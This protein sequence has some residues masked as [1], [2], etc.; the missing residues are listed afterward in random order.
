MRPWVKI[1]L[2]NNSSEESCVT[3]GGISWILT[4]VNL[5]CDTMTRI[6]W[7]EH[8]GVTLMLLFSLKINI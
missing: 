4:N 3:N 8:I 6:Y 2:V 5:K 7:D 1:R